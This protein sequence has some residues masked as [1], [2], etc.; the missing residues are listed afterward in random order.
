MRQGDA[1][2][3]ARQWTAAIRIFEQVIQN[4]A[5][6]W[7]AF[8]GIGYA[9]LQRKNLI[10]AIP[11]LI[12]AGKLNP[13]HE[14]LAQSL[15]HA[16]SLIKKIKKRRKEREAARAAALAER[17]KMSRA[18]TSMAALDQPKNLVADPH[19]T[20]IPA[21]GLSD[22]IYRHCDGFC[23]HCD[24]K[25][26]CAAYRKRTEFEARCLKD[27][28]DPHAIDTLVE[29]IESKFQA[30]R[31][32][33]EHDLEKLGITVRVVSDRDIKQEKTLDTQITG[34]QLFRETQK[35]S[36]QSRAFLEMIL[37][38]LEQKNSMSRR[39]MD[40]LEI[41]E[42]YSHF[43]LA[44]LYQALKQ[45]AVEATD[46]EAYKNL[47]LVQAAIEASLGAIKRL[48]M[49]NRREWVIEG[50]LLSTQVKELLSFFHEHYPDLKDYKKQIIFNA[51]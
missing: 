8:F 26:N 49:S 2:L 38:Y 5:K 24:L 17:E 7:E 29:E 6:N 10:K 22:E 28:K 9:Y 39:M 36:Q 21:D 45:L 48:T 34:S 23:S 4:D 13:R 40:D 18:T 43:G 12:W 11:F 19:P 32:F 33:L 14:R 27:G 20:K 41:L 51:R 31:D 50:S 30:M 25:N 37:K 3:D 15:R 42:H 47:A 1:K 16:Q 44:K 46:Q 35:F